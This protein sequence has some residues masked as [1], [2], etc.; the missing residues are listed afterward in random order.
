MWRRRERMGEGRG[1]E[2]EGR[3]ERGMRGGRG[4]RVHAC[5]YTHGSLALTPIIKSFLLAYTRRKTFFSKTIG[6]SDGLPLKKAKKQGEM[7]L[8]RVATVLG[9]PWGPSAMYGDP[10]EPS[11]VLCR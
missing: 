6:F 9:G 8:T 5:T 7:P 10:R 11:I 4:L 3:Y 2:G 1:G